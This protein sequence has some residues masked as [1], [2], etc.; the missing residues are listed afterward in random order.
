MT[1]STKPATSFWIISIVALV[2]NLLGVM[3]YLMHVTMTPETLQ[4]MSEQEQALYINTPVWANAAFA[5]A[6]WFSVLGCVLLLLRKKLAMPVFVIA[7]AGIVVQM[8]H[9]LFIS[10][11]ME[12]YGPG[13]MIMP[14]MVMV[15]GVY[16]IWYSRNA[17][18][19]GWL[20]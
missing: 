6:V 14:I 19:K 15:L 10:K 12:V 20:N 7:F 13:G 5:V 17:T 18:A 16:L 1:T 2:W 3:A 9:S 11:S 4:A 8:I